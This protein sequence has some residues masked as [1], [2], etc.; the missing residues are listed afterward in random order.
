MISARLQEE[1]NKAVRNLYRIADHAK[2][3]TNAAFRKAAPILIS[4]IQAG[5]PVSNASHSRYDGGAIVATYFPGNLKRSFK[6][7]T[8][9][10]SPAVWIGPKID[11]EGTNGVF[12]GNRTDGYY[13]HWI[14]FGTE[15]M[16]PHPFVRPAVAATGAAT[17]QAAVIELKRQI[18]SYANKIAV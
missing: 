7:L 18:D 3:E 13:A 2:K 15:K 16:A 17:L 9:R 14:E 1:V 5:A 10:R 6:T 4:A 12:K 11:K 8:F